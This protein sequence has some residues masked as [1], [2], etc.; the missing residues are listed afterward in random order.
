MKKLILCFV[1][2]AFFVSC[3]P[4]VSSDNFAR[5]T[6]DVIDAETLDPIEGARVNLSPSGKHFVT[7][8]DGYFDFTELEPLQYTITVQKTGYVTNRQTIQTFA[9]K[10]EDDF[11]I[12]LSRAE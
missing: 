4:S 1:L 12:T 5:I 6:G 10:I 7:G 2:L 9:G 3:E 8:S 11:R